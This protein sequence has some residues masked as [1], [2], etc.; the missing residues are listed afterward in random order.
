MF[1]V[2]LLFL[3]AVQ[4]AI[5]L[6]EAQAL[7][8]QGK[9]TEAEG[10]VRGYLGT[11]ADSAD[12][13]Y[14]LGYILFKEQNPRASLEQYTD[15]ARYREPSA[16][17]LETIGCDYFLMEDYAAAD[18]WLTK[19]VEKNPGDA[20]AQY[21]LGRAE[22]NEKH[23]NEAVRAFTECLKL[24]PNNVKAA[25]NL[26][27]SYEGLGKTEDALAAY[28][29]A[30]AL[31]TAVSRTNPGPYLN[32]GTLLVD[33]NRPSEAEPYLAQAAKIG[34]A[35]SRAHREL[36]KAFLQLNR[37]EEAQAELEKAAELAPQSAP[38]HF[39]L[40]QV[41]RKRGLA[42]KAQM[43]S[44]RYSAL[45]GAHSAPETPLAE[46]R[47][48]LDLGKLAEAEQVTRRYLEVRKNSAD[49]HYLLGYILFKNQDAKSSLAEY[50]EG[51]KYRKPSAA[52]LEVVASDYV[53]LKDYPDADKWFTKAVEWNPKDALGWYYL[54][55]TKYNENRFEE[56]IAAFQQCLKLNPK[57]VK[58]QDNLG[59]SYEGLNRTE[60]AAAAYRTAIEW[61]TDSPVK[62]AGPFLNL[63]SLLADGD[64]LDEGVSYL[65]N[66]A[67]LDPQDY[68]VHRQLGKAY[69]R[70]NQLEK[71]QAELEKAVELAPQN[72]PVHFMLAQ[73][74][75]KQ[76]LMEKAKTENDRYTAL[77][78]SN[79]TPK[80]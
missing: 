71:A 11:H 74:Y 37:L 46:A 78:G 57:D 1:A 28:R 40:A 62:N 8:D 23:F 45:T 35:D 50:T 21:F 60:E 56:A 34:P 33:N 69:T 41:F 72:A 43:E 70:L 7:L 42:D 68:R 9:L 14:L 31:D 49:A 6:V 73:V 77:V 12:A 24:D 39:L 5:P 61:E 59:L 54:G 55:R 58:A 13:H 44:E 66:A 64:G 26:G 27:L 76:G 80:D 4:T 2:V 10:A 30:I 16:L 51:A 52:D 79:S 75:R 22:Y 18:R 19:A 15:G 67:R 47:A 38:V 65:L 29:K 48:L 17:D 63:G 36:G 32:L 25:D 53:L 20:T 3:Q